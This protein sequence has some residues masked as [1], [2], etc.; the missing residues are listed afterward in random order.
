[1]DDVPKPWEFRGK[2]WTASPEL[3]EQE[4][5]RVRKIDYFEHEDQKLLGGVLVVTGVLSHRRKYGG[6]ESLRVRLK[7]PY[8]FPEVEPTVFDHD[9]VFKPSALG[10]QFGNWSLCLQ[11]PESG[12]FSRDAELL[13]CEVLGASLLWLAKRNIFERTGK[14]PGDEE[15]GYAAPYRR[16]A[17][18][19]AAES[20]SEVLQVWTDRLLD[21]RVYPTFGARCPCLRGRK[22]AEC[23]HK[24][25]DLIYKAI[26]HSM[27]EEQSNGLR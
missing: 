8:G 14:W 15:H 7:Y 10:H 21:S 6:T 17:I 9:R 19:C 1:M 27:Q 25:G 26:F 12:Q 18:E 23:H 4:V 16:L 3:I 22:L 11:F 20:G 5:R 24:L 13:T 2:R